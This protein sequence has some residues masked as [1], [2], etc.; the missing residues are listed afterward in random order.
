MNKIWNE[1]WKSEI[2]ESEIIKDI[3]KIP[4]FNVNCTDE[5]NLHDSNWTLLMGAAF[6][7]RK[8][9][10]RYLLTYPEININQKNDDDKTALYYAYDVSILK[11]F[12]T[13]RDIDVNIQ[14]KGWTV[15]HHMCYD[16]IIEIVQE[17]LLDVRV[18]VSIFNKFY[19]TALYIAIKEGRHGIANML[20][21]IRYTSLLRIPNRLLC[22]DIVRTIIEEYT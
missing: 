18:D 7:D 19:N 8:E 21:K 5:N 12:L 3:E 15:L 22:R 1:L 10:V 11:L 16:G 17:F 2:P 4:A 14:S 6:H 20:K 13:H 9:L